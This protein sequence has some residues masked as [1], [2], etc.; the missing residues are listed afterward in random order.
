MEILARQ[1]VTLGVVGLASVHP[2]HPYCSTSLL[3]RNKLVKLTITTQ[4]KLTSVE[5]SEK[6]QRN[7]KFLNSNIISLQALCHTPRLVPLDHV[8]R[9]EMCAT[10]PSCLY[11]VCERSK[12]HVGQSLTCQTTG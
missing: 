6:D 11:N 1:N 8:E 12:G 2:P 5:L 9:W 7:D 4:L 3:T 10:L